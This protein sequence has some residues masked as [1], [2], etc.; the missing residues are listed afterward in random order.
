M[1]KFKWLLGLVPS[2][3]FVSFF[4]SRSFCIARSFQDG[5]LSEALFYVDEGLLHPSFL[6]SFFLLFLLGFGKGIII[7]KEVFVCLPNIP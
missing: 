4:C 7:R 3:L 1:E 5:I 6:L 2:Y